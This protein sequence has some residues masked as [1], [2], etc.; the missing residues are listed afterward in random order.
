M[1]E[2]EDAVQVRVPDRIGSTKSHTEFFSAF[3]EM[4]A[5]GQVYDFSFEAMPNGADSSGYFSYW[6]GPDELTALMYTP[7]A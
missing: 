4:H 5:R 2:W 1:N 6:T 7:L 3:E